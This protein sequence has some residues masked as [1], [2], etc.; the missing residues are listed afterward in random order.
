MPSKEEV[1]GRSPAQVAEDALLEWAKDWVA[2]T[3]KDLMRLP[4][5]KSNPV[6]GHTLK[7]FDLAR[8]NLDHLKRQYSRMIPWDETLK[9][10]LDMALEKGPMAKETKDFIES[11]NLKK[12]S[13]I[14]GLADYLRVLV[15]HLKG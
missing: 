1:S 5:G 3:N 15:G 2:D 7:Q 12:A 13:S 14:G 9:A 11:L 6:Y 8:K 10:V 4:G